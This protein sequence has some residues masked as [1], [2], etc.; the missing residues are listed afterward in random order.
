MAPVSHLHSAYLHIALCPQTLRVIPT[1]DNNHPYIS[2]HS[3]A[4]GIGRIILIMS[5]ITPPSF[6]DDGISLYNRARDRSGLHPQKIAK[7][8]SSA[9]S[10]TGTSV[11]TGSFIDDGA[12]IPSPTNDIPGFGQIDHEFYKRKSIDK[13]EGLWNE[14][15]QKSVVGDMQRTM[16]KMNN[17]AQLD[18]R[19]ESVLRRE[20]KEGTLQ[21]TVAV[22]LPV[23]WDT[24]VIRCNDGR[25][26]V[27]DEHGEYDSGPNTVELKD[28]SG[29]E[30]ETRKWI[31]AASTITRPDTHEKSPMSKASHVHGEKVRK[32]RNL[33]HLFEPMAP[34]PE[35]TEAEGYQLSLVDE[36]PVPPSGC[37][38]TG[39]ASG[40]PS[41]ASTSSISSDKSTWRHRQTRASTSTKPNSISTRHSPPGSWP[42]P[43]QSISN[44]G[45]MTN[46]VNSWTSNRSRRSRDA[47]KSPAPVQYAE[48]NLSTKTHSTYRPPIVEDATK[49]ESESPIV[50][51]VPAWND[52]EVQ[53]AVE[54]TWGGDVERNAYSY[55][56]DEQGSEAGV[57]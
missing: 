37:L 50:S 44:S 42:S 22:P 49:T 45:L 43:P 10:Q 51:P 7:W 13:D 30:G 46:S 12:D 54:S 21:E 1:S 27:I 16:D 8:M 36:A 48:D 23:K 47:V 11:Y 24:F 53:S 20:T 38:M 25:V 15:V 39:G 55:V 34:I 26:I 9:A 14:H 35:G 2:R 40:W 19:R 41:T 6:A 57:V 3:E 5:S 28:K 4:I 33:W 56:V 52:E 18:V 17:L 32:Q 29:E 31:R